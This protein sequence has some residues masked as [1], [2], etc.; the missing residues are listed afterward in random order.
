MTIDIDDVREESAR[1]SN[2]ELVPDTKTFDYQGE[3]REVRVYPVT[4]GMANKLAEYEEGLQE[5]DPQ[6]VAV[7]LSTACPDLED[8]R[9]KDVEDMHLP[10]EIG[11]VNA[12][13]E[14]LPDVEIEGNR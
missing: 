12:V 13:A 2:G 10:F 9:K 7:V 14:Q 5:L 11:L 3:T 1:D 4:G 6:A 8:I